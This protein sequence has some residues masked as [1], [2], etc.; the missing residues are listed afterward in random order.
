MARRQLEKSRETQ[1]ELLVSAL[2]LFQE[3]GFF[4]TTIADITQKAGYAKG[5]F[6]RHWQSKDDL[7]LQL[8]ERKLAEHRSRRTSALARAGSMEEVLDAI[9]DFLEAIMQD[10]SWARVFLEFT[11]HASRHERLRAELAKSAYRL[12]DALFAQLVAGHVGE[13]VIAEKLGALNTCLFEGFLIHSVLETGTLKRADV[14]QAAM[15]LI[16]SLSGHQAG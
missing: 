6:Y 8:I 15:T 10:R 3:R 7:I 9:W 13:G 14:R 2:L 16:M 12:S 5:S 4:A 1:E 11:I